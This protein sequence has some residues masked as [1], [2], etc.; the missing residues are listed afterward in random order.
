MLSFLPSIEDDETLYSYCSTTHAL[1]GCRSSEKTSM[2][3]LGIAHGA[4]QHDLPSRVPQGLLQGDG[5]TR[6]V[7]A[8]LR[9]HTVAALYLPFLSELEQLDAAARFA[10]G[11][12]HARRRL[13]GSSRSL[14]APHALKA[15]ATCVAEDKA[16]I[17]RA[18]WHVV[19]QLPSCLNCPRH[20]EALV[21]RGTRLRTWCLPDLLVGRVTPRAEVSSLNSA[22]QLISCVTEELRRASTVDTVSLRAAAIQAL[23]QMSVLH[24]GRSVHAGQ[25]AKWFESTGVA[26][27]LRELGGWGSELSTGHW[28]ASQLWRRRQDHPIRWAVLWA[29]LDWPSVEHASFALKAALRDSSVDELGQMRLFPVSEMPTEIPLRIWEALEHCS[30]YEEVQ[31][32]LGITRATLLRWLDLDPK[33]RSAWKLRKRTDRVELALREVF[34]FARIHPLTCPTDLEEALPSHVRF[35][36]RHAADRLR[37][38]TK[39][40]KSRLPAQLK[41]EI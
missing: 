25:L 2:H 6:D 36:R 41:L 32:R 7:L 38:I 24:D 26:A 28:V 10:R 29:A 20:E 30:S 40:L 19:H 13:D 9:R 27:A 3:L 11:E 4:K 39:M 31:F 8:C 1:S 15:C 18:Y 33:L 5:S 21:S 16:R 23:R 37:N 22:H 17:G 14:R 34:K 12:Q 35:L